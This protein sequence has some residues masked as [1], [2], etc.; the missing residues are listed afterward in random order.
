MTLPRPELTEAAL[1]HLQAGRR[2]LAAACIDAAVRACPGD[3]QAHNLREAHRLPGCYTDW[4]GVFCGIHPADDIFRF[5]ANHPQSLNPVRDYLSD[6]WRSALELH[7]LLNSLGRPLHRVESFLEFACGHGRLTRHL[8]NDIPAARLTV[9]DVVA[10]TVDY[11]RDSLGVQGFY[12]STDPA[13]L[14]APARYDTVFVLSLFTHLPQATWG[15]WLKALH[16]LLNPGGLLVFSTHGEKCAHAAGVQWNDEGYAFFPDSESQA[17]GS[18]DY[19]VTY[20]SWD[21]VQAAIREHVPVAVNVSHHPAHFWG[22]QDAVA[23]QR[24]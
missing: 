3:V 22:N 19:G 2:D 8:V 4:T 9:S 12:S 5:F 6:G 21:F 15:P 7:R 20:T 18:A 1:L 23:L 16:E 24:A 13:Q 17:L 14:S 10:G 11:L